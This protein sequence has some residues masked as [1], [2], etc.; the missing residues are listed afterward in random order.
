MSRPAPQDD[1]CGA[2]AI[3]A[4]FSELRAAN[5]ALERLLGSDADE[6]HRL[7]E[8]ITELSDLARTCPQEPANLQEID[9]QIDAAERSVRAGLERVEPA[10]LQR[11]A[12]A[13]DDAAGGDCLALLEVLLRD[14]DEPD[15]CRSAVECLVTLLA[16]GVR[17][18]RRVPTRDPETL[19]PRLADRLRRATTGDID[20]AEAEATLLEATQRL[21]REDPDA[22]E[23]DVAELRARLGPTF[24]SP[25]V[26]RAL[27]FYGARSWQ[28]WESDARERRPS[29]QPAEPAAR[30]TAPSFGLATTADAPPRLVPDARTEAAPPLDAGLPESPS[31]P[32]APATHASAEERTAPAPAAAAPLAPDDRM[33]GWPGIHEPDAGPGRAGVGP[34]PAGPASGAPPSRPA[35]APD[36]RGELRDWKIPEAAPRPRPVPVRTEPRG[37]SLR[38][39]GLMALI[40]ITAWTGL[41]RDEGDVLVLDRS[42]LTAVSPWLEHGYRSE[43]GEHSIFV[44]TFDPDWERLAGEERE[45]IGRELARRLRAAGV[46]QILVYDREHRLRVQVAPGLPSSLGG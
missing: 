19:C 5:R 10:D 13:L 27:V 42:D 32:L 21:D 16:T 11:R 31:A 1:P 4:R 38:L 23:A 15:R 3:Q 17:N 8:A 33:E 18:G 25:I 35:A 12:V 43:S 20:A 14:D 41:G 34:R 29:A 26:L 30:D 2:H 36:A 46:S 28:R 45:Q 40:A 22:V 39:W 6:S 7:G 37:P 44:G 9:A 24:W